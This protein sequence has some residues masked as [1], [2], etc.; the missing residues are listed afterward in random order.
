[1]SAG[2][3]LRTYISMPGSAVF[4]IISSVTRAL[5]CASAG[6]EMSVAR[7]KPAVA[8]EILNGASLMF[9]VL[10]LTQRNGN[11]GD[12]ASNSRRVRVI[13]CRHSRDACPLVAGH[14]RWRDF[15]QQVQR[16]L[17]RPV[18]RVKI[19]RFSSD[20]NQRLF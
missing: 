17:P 5:V 7:K 3:L 1:M 16:D 2:R 18:S 14:A 15:P 13:Q 8:I 11:S 4:T 9:L 6:I 12:R 20:P 19:F 10:L